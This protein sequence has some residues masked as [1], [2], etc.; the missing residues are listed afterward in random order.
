MALIFRLSGKRFGQQMLITDKSGL[1]NF[2]RPVTLKAKPALSEKE[3]GHDERNMRLKRPQSPHLTIYAP[4]L[5]SMLSITHRFTGMALSAYAIAL[6]L[7][8]VV[9]PESIPHYI[10][11]LECA[12]IGSSCISAIKFILA[13]PI[14]YHFWNGIRHLLWD[15]GKFLTIREVYITGYVMLALAISSAIALSAM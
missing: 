3:E 5:T 2:V 1:F 11:E 10:E 15:A 4:Q 14:T 7:G 8:A 12:E 9:L 6:G 13:F